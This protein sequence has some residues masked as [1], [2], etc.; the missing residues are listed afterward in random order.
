MKKT[1]AWLTMERMSNRPLNS[2]GSSRIRARWLLNY[3]PE[4]EEYVIGKAYDTLCFQKV[5][6]KNMMEVFKGVKILDLSDPDWLEGKPV[7]EFIDLVDAVTT[8]TEALAEYIRKL[9]P[10]AFVQCVPDRVYIPECKPVKTRHEGVL[11]KL[12]WFGYSHNTHYLT[13]TFDELIK[14]N[15]QLTIISDN[16]FQ[17][18]LAYRNRLKIKNVP[19]DYSTVSREVV[20]ADA[21]LMPKPSG[22]EK[23]KYKSNNKTIQSWTQ[24]MPVVVTPEDLDKFM[25]PEARVEESKKRLREIKEKWSVELSVVQYRKIIE[26]IRVKKAKK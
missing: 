17:P 5:Y 18:P 9:R 12:V 15:I 24:G 4:A 11:E 7:F 10:K 8:S 6:W 16:P 14:R 25:K 1:T 21:V 19:Y 23:S 20:K 26:E 2:V 22:D 13:S 3:W